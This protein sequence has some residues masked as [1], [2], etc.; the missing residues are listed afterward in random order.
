MFYTFCNNYHQQQINYNCESKFKN[1]Y[2]IA[3]LVARRLN[4]IQGHGDG[5]GRSVL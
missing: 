2:E 1:A 3:Q 4:V 5:V